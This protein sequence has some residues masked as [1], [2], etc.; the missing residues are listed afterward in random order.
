MGHIYAAIA[1]KLSWSVPS[2]LHFTYI[3]KSIVSVNVHQ[4]PCGLT[5]PALPPLGKLPSPSTFHGNFSPSRRCSNEPTI[6]M[7]G[8][9]AAASVT[10]K[11]SQ[12]IN[13][14]LAEKVTAVGCSSS[15]RVFS[16]AA[17]A[18]R[19]ASWFEIASNRGFH[20][21]VLRQGGKAE[22]LST[23][24]TMGGGWERREMHC[25]DALLGAV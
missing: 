25:L 21:G 13:H 7:W 15:D 6:N 5:S 14:F 20:Q 4:H 3:T 17:W 22:V 10:H 23:A 16:A 19:P 2:N 24:Q 1:S 8:Q 9:A 12:W 11:Y 18:G